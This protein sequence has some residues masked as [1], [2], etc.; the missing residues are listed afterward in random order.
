MLDLTDPKAILEQTAKIRDL[1]HQRYE[2]EIDLIRNFTANIQQAAEGW[3]TIGD[4]LRAQWMRCAWGHSGP[5]NPS[6]ALTQTTTAFD[7]ALA[8]F[9]E[10][11]SLTTADAV[12]RAIDP[13]LTAA[14]AMYASPSTEFRSI[15]DATASAL[16]EVAVRGR[17]SDDPGGD[18]C[19]GARRRKHD[20]ATDGGQ[21][22]RGARG[23]GRAA[24]RCP[25]YAREIGYG[26]EAALSSLTQSLIDA[27]TPDAVAVAQQLSE[28]QRQTVLLAIIA[29]NTAGMD[30][31]ALP[32]LSSSRRRGDW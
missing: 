18:H 27:N 7:D 6:L 24:R 13:L 28:A 8:A 25:P 19:R 31:G 21:H 12:A 30:S 3:R 11:Q 1:I 26:D 16:E 10:D 17:T 20:R 14:S 5:T 15:F 22:G 23:T 2:G 29:Q 4:A 32:S 9:R